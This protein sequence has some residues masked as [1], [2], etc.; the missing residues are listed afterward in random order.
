MGEDPGR[1]C[2]PWG[3]RWWQADHEFPAWGGPPPG[4]ALEWKQMKTKNKQG[5]VKKREDT[6]IYNYISTQEFVN[7]QL[8]FAAAMNVL[9]LLVVGICILIGAGVIKLA[10]RIEE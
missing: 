9:Y 4:E 8:S 7:N 2:G 6:E 1:G 5:K 10:G 3:K